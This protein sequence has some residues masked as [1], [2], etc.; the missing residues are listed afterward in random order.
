VPIRDV[1]FADLRII[2]ESIR[3]VAAVG[4]ADHR[5]A[6]GVNNHYL[7]PICGSRASQIR[8]PERGKT[9]C[10]SIGTGHFSPCSQNGDAAGIERVIDDRYF[11]AS[12]EL[13][14]LN[15]ILFAGGHDLRSR[16]LPIISVCARAR[17]IAP[18]ERC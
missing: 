16:R 4:G 5:W 1:D 12:T 13:N 2:R 18:P 6:G 15:T 7:V 9:T 8:P 3:I 10:P 14:L 11:M 17:R